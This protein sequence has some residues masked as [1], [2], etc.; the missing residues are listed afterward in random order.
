MK[1]FSSH[2][3]IETEGLR[4]RWDFSLVYFN[5]TDNDRIPSAITTIRSENR[6]KSCLIVGQICGEY[7]PMI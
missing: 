2:D 5:A 1:I 7:L 3:P 6:S 4:C